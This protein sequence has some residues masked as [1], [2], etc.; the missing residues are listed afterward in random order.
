MRG[1]ARESSRRSSR[2]GTGR[3]RSVEK[4]EDGG[5][6]DREG[7]GERGQDGMRCTGLVDRRISLIFILNDMFEN[8]HQRPLIDSVSLLIYPLRACIHFTVHPFNCSLAHH[9]SPIIYAS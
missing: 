6:G 1:A 2:R 9:H 3:H 8:S 5:D 7:E 4:E